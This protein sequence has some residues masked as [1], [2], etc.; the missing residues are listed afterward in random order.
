MDGPAWEKGLSSAG[1]ELI[2]GRGTSEGVD[3][4]DE[5]YFRPGG[6]STERADWE[7]LDTFRVIAEVLGSSRRLLDLGCGTGSITPSVLDVVGEYVGLEGSE[8]AV[9]E[10]QR[11]YAGPKAAFQLYNLEGERMP[12]GDAS[13]DGILACHVLEHLDPARLPDTLGEVNRVLTPEGRFLAIVPNEG[14]TY[15][16]ALLR[17]WGMGPDDPT[18][19]SFF[20]AKSLARVVSSPLRVVDVFTYP[21]PFLWRLSHGLARG[22]SFRFG[23]NIYVVATKWEKAMGDGIP[24]A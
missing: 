19:R 24:A 1:Q 14:P 22:L 17:R 21:V 4:Y 8:Y 5:A 23:D 15:R 18:H 3:P 16:K 13:F 11:L 12:F 6:R 20:T 7:G 9:S 10:A 2:P